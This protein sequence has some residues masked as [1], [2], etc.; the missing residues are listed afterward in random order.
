MTADGL[1]YIGSYGRKHNGLWVASGFNKWGMTGSMMAAKIL[2]GESNISEMPIAHLESARVYNPEICQ[3]LGLTVPE[4][5][6][7]IA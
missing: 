7:P 4:G 6:A 2:T 3:A 5:Y 1:P